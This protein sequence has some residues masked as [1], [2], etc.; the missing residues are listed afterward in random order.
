MTEEVQE[1][2]SWKYFLNEVIG[3][4]WLG[5]A[6]TG[7]TVKDPSLFCSFVLLTGVLLTFLKFGQFN[8]E[9]FALSRK[10]R[11]EKNEKFNH[12]RLFDYYSRI[13]RHVSL[14]IYWLGCG[15]VCL[16]IFLDKMDKLDIVKPFIG[17]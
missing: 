10:L 13:T 6:M 1:F 16:V 7:M 4:F 17:L 14:S 5:G 12:D 2:I 8:T 15:A 9:L 11:K 3:I